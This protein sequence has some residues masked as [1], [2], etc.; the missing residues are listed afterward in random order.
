VRSHRYRYVA[1]RLMDRKTPLSATP[2]AFHWSM[3]VLTEVRHGDR[4]AMSLPFPTM[5]T[6]T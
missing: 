3:A 1:E 6:S 2:A 4:P 5:L